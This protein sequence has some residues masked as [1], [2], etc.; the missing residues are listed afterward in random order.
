LTQGVKDAKHAVNDVKKAS[1]DVA[2]ATGDAKQAIGG[3]A[4]VVKDLKG[5]GGLFHKSSDDAMSNA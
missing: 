4:Q 3:A 5:I 1:N 2:V